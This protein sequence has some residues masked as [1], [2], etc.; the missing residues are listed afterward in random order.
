MATLGTAYVQI[1][2]SV[3]GF[4]G[5]LQGPLEKETNESAQ[6]V[7]TSMGKKLVSAA[8]KIITVA[9]IGETL[10]KAFQLGADYE[11]LTGG[12]EKIFGKSSGTIMKYA[13][14]AYKTSGI[15]ANKYMEQ[16]TSF[17]ASLVSAMGGNTKGAA[18]KAN[19]AIVDMSD[20]AS[21]YGSNITDIQNAYQGFAKQNYTIKLMSVA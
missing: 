15:S 17:S 1:L 2:P 5:E 16:V 20:N 8:A 10:S 19:T 7:G 11:Q 3:K 12:V 18:E 21:I 13:Q 6:Q 9:K 4:K 14:D